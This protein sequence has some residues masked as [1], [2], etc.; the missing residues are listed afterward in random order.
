MTGK[1]FDKP[2]VNS[3][4][5]CEVR[6]Q[7]ERLAAAGS[8]AIVMQAELRELSTMIDESGLD[9]ARKKDAVREV[10]KAL[11]K[12]EKGDD[13]LAGLSPPPG[14]PPCHGATSGTHFFLCQKRTRQPGALERSCR[15]RVIRKLSELR[16]ASADAQVKR[17]APRPPCPARARTTR[18]CSWL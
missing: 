2:N 12:L 3:L 9:A 11:A 5:K 15:D 14:C 18:A 8:R 17:R 6:K 16:R 4:H 10:T 13:P 7:A 1:A